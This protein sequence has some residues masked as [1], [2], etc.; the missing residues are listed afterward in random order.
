ML[1]LVQV[2]GVRKPRLMIHVL[3]GQV[4]SGAGLVTEVSVMQ[5][6][7]RRPPHLPPA[8][9]LLAADVVYAR[10]LIPPLVSLIR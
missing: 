6:D 4:V 5:V 9:L 3:Y 10:H 1:V 8:D 2:N 7:W